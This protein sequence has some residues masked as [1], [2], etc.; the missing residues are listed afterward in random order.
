MNNEKCSTK[1][2]RGEVSVIHLGDPLC[3]K[4]WG[5]MCDADHERHKV[6]A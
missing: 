5:K 2:C 4:C 3:E 1:Y 6:R